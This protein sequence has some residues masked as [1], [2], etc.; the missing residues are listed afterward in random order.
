MLVA[1]L[2]IWITNCVGV[3]KRSEIV[4]LIHTSKIQEA[5]NKGRA[6]EMKVPNLAKCIMGY[7][8]ALCFH[9]RAS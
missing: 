8:I 6:L 4:S 5:R 1:K 2:R 7:F 3:G 9:Y